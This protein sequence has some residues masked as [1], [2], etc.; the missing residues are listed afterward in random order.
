MAIQAGHWRLLHHRRHQT[1]NSIAE[2]NLNNNKK[3]NKQREKQKQH[4]RQ[5]QAPRQKQQQQPL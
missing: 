3:V 5:Q 1:A 4:P 2:N